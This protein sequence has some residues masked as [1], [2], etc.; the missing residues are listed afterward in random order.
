VVLAAPFLTLTLRSGL[1]FKPN[2]ILPL[3]AAFVPYPFKL[4]N[5]PPE[6]GWLPF[7][8]MKVKPTPDEAFGLVTGQVPTARSV[9]TRSAINERQPLEPGPFSLTY[10]M[11]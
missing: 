11:D 5:L 8:R 6:F 2:P 1:K 4:G 10:E 7:G 9:E 3:C